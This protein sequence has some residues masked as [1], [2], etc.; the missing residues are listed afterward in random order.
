M[1]DDLKDKFDDAILYADMKAD[2][3]G[4]PFA[5]VPRSVQVYEVHRENKESLVS[6][7]THCV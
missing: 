5:Q 7:S 4:F 2:I 1:R 3:A 6:D